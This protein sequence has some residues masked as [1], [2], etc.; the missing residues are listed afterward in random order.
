MLQFVR[1]SPDSQLP[2]EGSHFLYT[3]QPLP[4]PAHTPSATAAQG[5]VTTLAH[6]TDAS[7]QVRSNSNR[8]KT[9]TMIERL[10]VWGFLLPPQGTVGFYVM[11]LIGWVLH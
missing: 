2:I 8:N 1:D 7:L 9:G 11:L 3:S 10:F 6:C 4:S 5:C